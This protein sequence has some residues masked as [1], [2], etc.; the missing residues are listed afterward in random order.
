MRSAL[1]WL[2]AASMVGAALAGCGA[3]GTSLSGGGTGNS[4]TGGAPP[5]FGTAFIRVLDAS[6]DTNSAGTF[7]AFDVYVDNT[8]VWQNLSY[9]NFNGKAGGTG[10]APFYITS[11]LA[12]PL[13]PTGHNVT[14]YAAG[15]APGN[16]TQ[17]ASASTA[18]GNSRT[19]VVIMDKAFNTGTFQALAYTEPVMVSPPG[20]DDNIYIFHA[21]EGAAGTLA[22]GTIIGGGSTKAVTTFRGNITFTT[23]PSAV[24]LGKLPLFNSNGAPTAFY[25]ANTGRQFDTTP[26]A[27]LSPSSFPT[28]PP[29]VMGGIAYPTPAP[30]LS[31]QPAPLAFDCD[32]TFPPTCGGTPADALAALPNFQMFAIDAPPLTGQATPQTAIVGV[33]DSNTP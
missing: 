24:T 29:P 27:S 21:A 7:V 11:V 1:G 4:G 12:V 16:A 15:A 26:I 22:W 14:V 13:S 23:P 9:A 33:F 3:N 28:P 19:T 10:T 8:R 32:N 6:P 2:L 31:G 20:V 30:G 18:P 25:V 5:A 17:L